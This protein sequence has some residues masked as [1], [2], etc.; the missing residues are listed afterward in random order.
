MLDGKGMVGKRMVMYVQ[1][2]VHKHKEQESNSTV[3][4]LF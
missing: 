4:R 1:I 2:L 3:S